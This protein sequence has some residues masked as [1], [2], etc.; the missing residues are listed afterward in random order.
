MYE[1]KFKIVIILKGIIEIESVHIKMDLLDSKWISIFCLHQE[2]I[3]QTGL[4]L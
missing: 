2:N 4:K 1:L 3:I